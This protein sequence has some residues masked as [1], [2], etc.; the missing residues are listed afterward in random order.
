MRGAQRVPIWG[1]RREDT[2][3]IR[4]GFF[5]RSPTK[6]N[7]VTIGEAERQKFEADTSS[8]RRNATRRRRAP[9]A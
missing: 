6:F 8:R 4:D 3:F 2:W 1:E 9:A 7:G 5:V